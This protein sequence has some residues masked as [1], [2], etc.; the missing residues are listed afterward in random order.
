M[1]RVAGLIDLLRQG[2]RG[3]SP[4]N[5]DSLRFEMSQTDP[6]FARVRQVQHDARGLIGA[7]RNAQQLAQRVLDGRAIR[8]ERGFWERHGGQGG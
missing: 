1:R 2:V 5:P 7:S 6:D 8:R 4:P 3:P